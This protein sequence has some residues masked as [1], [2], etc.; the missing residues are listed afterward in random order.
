VFAT[1]DG[2][3]GD[4]FRIKIVEKD[5]DEVVYDNGSKT[6]IGGG[7]IKVHEG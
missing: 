7:D 1:D 2:P 5:T 6:P 4:A 3:H